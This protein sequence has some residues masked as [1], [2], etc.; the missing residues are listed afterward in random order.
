MRYPSCV[1]NSVSRVCRAR[2]L[3]FPNLEKGVARVG[4][5]PEWVAKTLNRSELAEHQNYGR[6]ILA[7]ATFEPRLRNAKTSCS[8][9]KYTIKLDAT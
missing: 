7:E 5:W 6:I 3:Q 8:D 4:G 1:E 9:A 2:S